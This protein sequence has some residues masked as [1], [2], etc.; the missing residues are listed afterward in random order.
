MMSKHPQLRLKVWLA[1]AFGFAM[2]MF[3]MDQS[4]LA[5][6]AFLVVGVLLAVLVDMIREEAKRPMQARDLARVLYEEIANRVARCVFDF[7]QP[8]EKWIERENCQPHEVDVMRLQRFIPIPPTIYPATA[9]QLALL[10]GK[11]PQAVIRFH[12]ALAVYQ[13]DMQDVAQLCLQRG[14]ASVSPDFVHL[15]AGRLR[16]TLRPGLVA[17]RELAA[18]VEDYETIDAEAIREADSHF[19]HERAHLTLRQRIEHYVKN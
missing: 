7:E 5:N 9:G 15:L 3:F 17:L 11:V 19:K 12:V 4:F 1:V 2:L 13:R 8:W 6:V 14:V 18:F 16:R 10:G